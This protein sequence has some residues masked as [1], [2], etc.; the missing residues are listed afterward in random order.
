MKPILT[1]LFLSLSLL[2]FGQTM[3]RTTDSIAKAD[4]AQYATDSLE[5]S[6]Q[7]DAWWNQP[8]P[9]FIDSLVIPLN[10]SVK[11]SIILIVE[12]QLTKE[13]GGCTKSIHISNYNGVYTIVHDANPEAFYSQPSLTGVSF[14]V[15]L[16]PKGAPYMQGIGISA[17][18]YW[19]T[20]RTQFK[21]NTP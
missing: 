20:K 13:T 2:S 5:S 6:I 10:T 8:G 21:L 11:M 12:N 9:L 17:P 15:V 1:I 19:S 14:S 18:I 4:I 3:E 16:P 7:R